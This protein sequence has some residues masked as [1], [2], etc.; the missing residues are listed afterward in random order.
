[1]LFL[2]V[3]CRRTLSSCGMGP[4][5]WLWY[6][7][8]SFV[9]AEFSSRIMVGESPLGNP[10]W[11]HQR[12]CGSSRVSVGNSEFFSNCSGKLGVPLKLKQGSWASS[13]A[14]LGNLG[15]FSRCYRGIVSHLELQSGA[16]CFSHDAVGNTEFLS[17]CGGNLWVPHELQQGT[18]NSSHVAAGESGLIQMEVGTSGLFLNCGGKLRVSL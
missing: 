6:G 14:A 3:M 5:L 1:M 13:R 2:V 7:V 11:L 9:V 16:Q 8:S 12:A 10:L 15:V 4:P 17:S 18:Q